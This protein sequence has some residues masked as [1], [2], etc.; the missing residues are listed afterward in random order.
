LSKPLLSPEEVKELDKELLDSLDLKEVLNLVGDALFQWFENNI[1]KEQ[2]TTVLVGPGNNG[3]DGLSLALKLLQHSYQVEVFILGQEDPEPADSA[4]AYYLKNLSSV[5]KKDFS[6]EKTSV[7]VDALFGIGIHSDLRGEASQWVK[8]AN[9][10]ED[11][12]K[13]SVDIPSGVNATTGKAY[14]PCFR[15]QHTLTIGCLKPGLLLFPGKEHSGL[16]HV[17][18]VKPISQRVS[19]FQQSFFCLP[20][21]SHFLEKISTSAQVHK[22]KR[23]KVGVVLCET[24]PGASLMTAKA[25][26]LSGAG[27]VEVYCPESLIKNCQIEHPSLVFRPYG[28]DKKLTSLL[29]DSDCD[30]FILGPGWDLSIEDFSELLKSDQ[31]ILL[32]GGALNQEGRKLLEESQ[33]S[34][35]VLTPHTGELSR[36]V[37]EEDLTKFEKAEKLSHDTAAVVV[38]KGYD[39]LICQNKTWITDWNET[40]LAVAG[41]GDILAGIIGSFMA[42]GL[43]SQDAACAGVGVHRRLGSERKKRTTPDLMLQD[44]PKIIERVF[45]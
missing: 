44:L 28:E 9:S 24:Y 41:S 7:C 14:E 3:N 20:E 11:L 12:L 5:I 30:S 36:M 40:S 15:A 4:R 26:Q 8:Q 45:P 16:S 27:Y 43:T 32:D 1:S 42:Q 19:K 38:A 22:Y 10:K 29:S 37:E 6:L 31:K 17:I 35:I 21:P 13:I 18:E 23:G 39:T 2:T 34:N 25:S 33:N